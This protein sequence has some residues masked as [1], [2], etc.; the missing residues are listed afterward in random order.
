MQLRWTL[1][2]YLLLMEKRVIDSIAE[3]TVHLT[4]IFERKFFINIKIPPNAGIY[5]H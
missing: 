3:S 4:K 5:L 1:K 2:I